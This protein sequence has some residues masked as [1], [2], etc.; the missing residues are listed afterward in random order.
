ML[1]YKDFTFDAAHYLTKVPQGH[2][3]ATMHGHTYH[4]RL[5]LNGTVD[6]N[7]WVMDFADIKIAAS[8]VLDLIDHQCLN[9]VAGLENPTCELLAI[10]I[11][12]KMKPELPLLHKIALQETPTSGV[13]YEGI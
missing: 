6:E 13:E 1:L 10:W 5:W 8:K 3:C 11:W 7:G 2:K 12:N 4:L 9:H